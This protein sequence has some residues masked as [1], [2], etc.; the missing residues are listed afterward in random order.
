MTQR[1]IRA[2]VGKIHISNRVIVS[3]LIFM[4]GEVRSHGWMTSYHFCE[5]NDYNYK[6]LA[7][8]R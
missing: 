6:L 2:A 8:K 1:D 3:N 4:K 7:R 5:V